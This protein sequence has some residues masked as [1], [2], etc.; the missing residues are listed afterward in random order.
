MI[1]SKYI[2]Y[3]KQ[4]VCFYSKFI[5][6]TAKPDLN[7]KS[8]NRIVIVLIIILIPLS[9]MCQNSSKGGNTAASVTE[10]IL[11]KTGVQALPKT[12]DV[13]KIGRAHV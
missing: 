12:V 8:S 6:R 3:G 4:T 11:I 1:F 2:N 7:M 13:I 9:T 10:Q 5:V